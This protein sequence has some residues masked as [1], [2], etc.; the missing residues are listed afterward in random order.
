MYTLV[1]FYDDIY[2]VCTSNQIT[3]KKNV[4]KATYSDKRSYPAIIL[5]KNDNKYI[6]QDIKKNI[7]TNKPHILRKRTDFPKFSDINS[8]SLID[9]NKGNESVILNKECITK[10]I[11]ISLNIGESHMIMSMD[12]NH[13]YNEDVSNRDCNK[14]LTDVT[15]NT[16][17]NSISLID[18]NKD[19][20]SVILNKESITKNIDVSLNIGASDMIM[21]MDER[22]KN[23]ESVPNKDSNEEMTDATSNTDKNKDNESVILNKKS[24]TK[25]IDVSLNIGASDMIMSMDERDKNNESVPNKDSNEEMTDATSNTDINSISLINKNKGNESV[26]LNKESIT[27]NMMFH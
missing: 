6:L 2:H 23:N 14:K 27:K 8:I 15:S 17:I 25:N 3:I 16:D 13:K 12:E 26:I 1:K 5:V 24:I 18:K 11:D 22:D 21:S 20:E 4:T 7:I 10:N 9:K 19:N